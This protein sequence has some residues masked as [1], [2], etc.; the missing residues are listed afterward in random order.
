PNTINILA[1][2]KKKSIITI[3]SFKSVEEKTREDWRKHLYP[4]LIRF[5][6]N[7]SGKIITVSKSVGLDLKREFK[8]DPKIIKP[9]YNSF[10]IKDILKQSKESLN[11]SFFHQPNT[12]VIITVSRICPTKAIWHIIRVFNE[13][14]KYDN[15]MRL[16]ILG[17]TSG[18]DYKSELTKLIVGYNIEDYVKIIDFQNNPF[19][20]LKNSD[21]YVSTS[22][23]EGFGN[24]I[25]ES[26]ACGLP[27][28]HSD[29]KAGP[30]EILAP[31]TDIDFT[32]SEIELAE[33][34]ILVPPCEG[35]YMNYKVPLTKNEKITLNAILLLLSDRKLSNKYSRKGI[36]RS[37]DFDSSMII[38]EYTK[39]IED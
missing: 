35:I 6:Y 13:I 9:I 39:I 26:M 17:G 29:C 36:E 4:L 28:I 18:I 8:I 22:I 32:T 11:D 37:K 5:L 27:V 30:R 38:K 12:R 16:V 31:D 2:K 24:V 33:Y 25:I 23:L 34:G 7:R 19:Q 1:N 21:L 20:Y 3:H 10:D 14:L 15:K